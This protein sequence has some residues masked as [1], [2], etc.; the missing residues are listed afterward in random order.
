MDHGLHYEIPAVL[1]I[2]VTVYYNDLFPWEWNW[3]KS[4]QCW[5]TSIWIVFVIL[6]TRE[7]IQSKVKKKKKVPSISSPLWFT[8]VV[9]Q[10]PLGTA[11]S[12]FIWKRMN[13]MA[14][15][16]GLLD[17]VVRILPWMKVAVSLRA[18]AQWSVSFS[19]SRSQQ[20]AAVPVEEPEPSPHP[21]PVSLKYRSSLSAA[22]QLTGGKEKNNK[23]IQEIC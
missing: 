20:A 19:P 4:V 10:Q 2:G 15:E 12:L 13:S 8:S 3:T 18:R 7:K 16:G 9:R 21:S 14:S 23:T 5:K 17:A 1:Y 22:T 6:T 11:H